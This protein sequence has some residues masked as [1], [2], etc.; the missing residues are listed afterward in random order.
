MA[1]LFDYLR[2]RGDIRF[3]Q[4]PMNSV[5]ALIFSALAYVHYED[6]VSSVLDDG[7]PLKDAAQA[8]LAQ[9]DA[10][11]RCRVKNDLELLKAA[12]ETERFGTAR[13]CC[14]RSVFLPEKATQFA[15]LAFLLCDGTA[16]LAFRGTDNTLVGWKEDFNMSFQ[17]SIPAQRLAEQYTR[18]FA[19]MTTL[20]LYL[21]GH[22]KGG[23]LA[24]FSAATGGTWVQNRIL[25]VFNQ[26][27]PG[28]LEHITKSEGY[29]R[30]LPKIKTYVPQ[31]S[32]IGMVLSHQE[33]HI[34]IRS[35]QLG[36]MQHDLYSWEVMG[37]DF[38][39]A[40]S[41]TADSRFWEQTFHGWIDGMK[42]EERSHFFDTLFRLLET[43]DAS[44]PRDIMKPQNLL[45]Y[46]RALS[47]DESMRK[48]L[49]A[50]LS[51]LLQAAKDAQI[52]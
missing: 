20:P 22:S 6:A 27:G 8:V 3:S 36:I 23:N 11:S 2:W 41:M 28:F 24:V 5:D 33:P 30:I 38:L 18:D 52:E 21:T 16:C 43:E 42:P 48:T 44:H 50:E 47:N 39:L 45:T 1:D 51:G 14:Y 37:A 49:K 35:K 9:P 26:D 40:E 17:E 10:A 12:A 19:G 15:A 34:I 31:S 7:I 25:A 46:I 4:V 13:L 32:I 29:I